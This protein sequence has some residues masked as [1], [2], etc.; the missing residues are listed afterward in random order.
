MQIMK[1]VMIMKRAILKIF[2]ILFIAF[3][4]CKY[5]DY[6]NNE[7][8]NYNFIL[9]SS[10]NI[11]AVALAVTAIFFTVID[12]Y[13]DKQDFKKSIET[14]CFPV[15]EE[16]C[17][18]VLGILF[19]VIFMFIV[20]VL[21]PLFANFVI[22]EFMGKFSFSNFIYL[23]SFFFILAILYDITKSVLDLTKGL[24]SPKSDNDSKNNDRY[25]S[26]LDICKKL[27][28]KHFNELLEYTKTIFLKQTLE[29]DSEK[30][31]FL[32]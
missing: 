10:I 28:D 8:I 32:K 15:L 9:S 25:T 1:R 20:S 26:L 13:K 11:L 4:C 21:E 23:A 7:I 14:S 18:N 2:L 16:M 19:A 24:S 3:I 22:P 31:N 17:Q 12:R 5:F 30:N 6:S 27:D 29:K